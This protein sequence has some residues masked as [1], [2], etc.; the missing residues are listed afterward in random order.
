MLRVL[1][2]AGVNLIAKLIANQSEGLRSEKRPL[3]KN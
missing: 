3:R 2:H 1:N